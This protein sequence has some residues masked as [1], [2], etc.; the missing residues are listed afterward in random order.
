VATE[1][2]WTALGAADARWIV[3]LV[4]LIA[5]LG[6]LGLALIIGLVPVHLHRLTL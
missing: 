1:L 2:G 6:D 4:G 5:V 3:T